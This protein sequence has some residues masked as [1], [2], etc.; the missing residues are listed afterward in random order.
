MPMYAINSL[1]ISHSRTSNMLQEQKKRMGRLNSTYVL[2]YLP[3]LTSAQKSKREC[4]I[5]T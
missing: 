3:A 4:L 1:Y 5:Y 2:T